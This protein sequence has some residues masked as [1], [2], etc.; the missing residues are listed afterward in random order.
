MEPRLYLLK[1]PQSE[2]GNVIDAKSEGSV[3]VSLRCS[4]GWWL[5]CN[6]FNGESNSEIIFLQVAA[7]ADELLDAVCR[8][9]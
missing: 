1:K 6:K 2:T 7:V 8:V 9:L 5:Y 4:G 3:A